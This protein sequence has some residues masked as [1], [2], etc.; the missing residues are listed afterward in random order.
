MLRPGCLRCGSNTWPWGLKTA[1]LT[2]RPGGQVRVSRI[3]DIACCMRVRWPGCAL[4]GSSPRLACPTSAFV[5]FRPGRQIHF[6]R[7]CIRSGSMRLTWSDGARWGLNLRFP[8]SQSAVL[9]IRPDA[10]ITL[11]RIGDIHCCLLPSGGRRG[12]CGR[13]RFCTQHPTPSEAER[14]G[15]HCAASGINASESSLCGYAAHLSLPLL[16]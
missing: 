2:A 13:P 1:V 9:A 11:S 8:G 6:S 12:C 14:E 10:Q 15:G 3:G 4:R 7:V 5:A 16:A